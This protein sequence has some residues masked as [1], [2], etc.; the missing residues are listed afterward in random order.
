MANALKR[1]GDAFERL[2][3]DYFRVCGFPW[4]ERTKAGYERDGGDLH[5]DA[6]IGMSPGVICQAKNVRTPRWR[7]WV[8]GL[9]E[10]V[11]NAHADVGFIA[12]KLQGSAK[13][14]EQ[15][16]F[17]PL[18]EF[19]HLVRRAGYGNPIEEYEA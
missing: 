6:V 19:L 15:L 11:D 1:K 9:R 14:E 17:M 16:A 5:L 4:C 10:Q 2:L 18:P 12:L 8:N 13:P 7:D 3:R